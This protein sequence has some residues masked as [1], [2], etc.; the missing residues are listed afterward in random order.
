MK[1]AGTTSWRFEES[2]GDDM[3]HVALFVRDA[4]GLAVPPG[5]AVPPPL[6]SAVP[7]HRG[8]LSDEERREAA[9]EWA[10]WWAAVIGFE[11]Q[12]QPT[13][14]DPDLSAVRET[15]RARHERTGFPPDFAVL[16]DRPALHRAVVETF[17][18]GRSWVNGLRLEH[19]SR[20]GG[21][22]PYRLV[23]QVAEDVAFD[24]SVDVGDVRASALVLEVEGS[25]WHLLAAGRVV[26][27]AAA[28]ANS[29]SA[30]LVLRQAFESGLPR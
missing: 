14:S 6:S 1:V 22:F 18:H 24:R 8:V 26:C 19:R 13:A 28:T 17:A 25:W 15:L 9:R 2:A 16:A 11:V 10:G 7:D 12:A 5:P 30:Q 23:R 4:V 3:P 21:R 29:V 27:S 20:R